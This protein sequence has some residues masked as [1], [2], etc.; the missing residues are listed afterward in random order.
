[1]STP[2]SHQDVAA[3]T[4][5]APHPT[6]PVA[7]RSVP[8]GPTEFR[9]TTIPGANTYRLQLAATDEFETRYYDKTVDGPV[10]LGLSEVLPTATGTIAWR[11][12]AEAPSAPWSET[13]HLTVGAQEDGGEDGSFFVD[14][15]PVP[16]RPATNA[17]IDGGVATFEWE[18]VPE[19]SG[20]R[21]QVGSTEGFDD[22][23]VDL[24]VDQ[25]T[26]VRL[27]DVLPRESS[28]YW[29][30]CALFPTGAEGPWGEA[31]RF[32]TEVQRATKAEG[33]TAERDQPRQRSSERDSPVAAGPAR[34]SHTSSTMALLVSAVL[35]VSFLVTVLLIMVLG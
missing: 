34:R 9:W 14:A 18:G 2:P 23:I 31:T 10:T 13:A 22:P 3:K 35:L 21:I 30:V 8:S 26:T 1:M 4:L 15:P 20:Y 29:R 25:T 33:D 6:H 11:V 7:G 16:V 19:A 12:R 27:F 17:S 5:P 28:V 32:L 24:T